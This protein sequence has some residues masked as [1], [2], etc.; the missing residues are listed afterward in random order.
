MHKLIRRHCGGGDGGRPALQ[1][2]PLPTPQWVIDDYKGMPRETYAAY[3]AQ[4]AI[5]QSLA[6]TICDS[7]ILLNT[8]LK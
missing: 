5:A 3:L 8:A 2:E 6:P 1:P 7:N 4:M